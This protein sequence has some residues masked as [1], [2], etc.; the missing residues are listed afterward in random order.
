MSL[1]RVM[2]ALYRGSG[3]EDERHLVVDRSGGLLVSHSLPRYSDLVRRGNVWSAMNTT[4]LASLVVRPSTV[5]NLTLFNNE[6]EGGK[7][8]IVLRAFAFQLVSTAAQGFHALWLC[9]H[10][11]GLASPTNDITARGSMVCKANYGGRAIVDTAMTVTDNGW[12]PWSDM[13]L[14]VESV[15]VLPGGTLQANVDGAIVVPPQCG[16]STQ[17]V[18]SVVGNTFTS[19]FT[20]AEEQLDI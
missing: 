1:A 5:A 11:K 2:K 4:A 8:Y 9:P 7:S 12:F 6:P 20:W 3:N 17:V 16:V 13:I 19:G 15:G 10:P 14:Q 18:G